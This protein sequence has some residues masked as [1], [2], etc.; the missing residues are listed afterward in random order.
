VTRPRPPPRLDQLPREA[1]PTSQS[2]SHSRAG[3]WY[4]TA[5]HQAVQQA[6][7]DARR[8][9]D[10]G[11]AAW[12]RATLLWEHHPVLQWI[13]DRVLCSFHRHEAPLILTPDLAPGV[14]LFL[15]Q[16]ILSN[17]QGQPVLV[18]W[19]GVRRDPRGSLVETDLLS[20]EQIL[21]LAHLDQDVP[22]AGG[23][24]AHVE[25]TQNQLALAVKEA[26]NHLS[27]LRNQRG[28]ELR[29]TLKASERSFQSWARRARDRVHERAEARRLP[30]GKLPRDIQE[31]L[32][33]DLLRI[34][35]RLAARRLWLRNSM[36]TED[37][38]YLRLAAV[39][40]GRDGGAS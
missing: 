3:T 29:E 17:R 16:G 28:E 19:F 39:L 26:R 7:R 5:D 21:D 13:T 38:P 1:L 20:F 25:A 12:P 35:K 11:Q 32:D 36:T 40:V 4:L 34:D 30:G 10:Q 31:K 18:D 2:G 27:R 22:N 23:G 9:G 15:F 33:Q 8:S 14:A 37:R 6:I 24:E